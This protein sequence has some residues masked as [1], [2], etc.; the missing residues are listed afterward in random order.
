MST[1]RAILLKGVAD[2]TARGSAVI[3]FPLIAAY[4]GAAGYGAY[5]QVSTI[6]SFVVP[7][8]SLGIA[9]AMVRY[10]AVGGWTR[11]SAR[12]V[13]RIGVVVVTL[14]AVPASA[15]AIFAGPLNDALLGWPLGGALFK[16]GSL[17]IVLG[18]SELWLLELFRA[19]DWLVPYSLLQL[20]Q[21]LALVVAMAVLLPSGHTVVAL[22]Q[23]AVV[24]KGIAVGIALIFAMRLAR[25]GREEPGEPRQPPRLAEMIR[26]GLPFTIAGFGL[27]MVNLSDRLVIGN[28]EGPAD[29]GRYGAA[30]TIASLLLIVSAP[31]MLPVYRRYMTASLTDDSERIAADTRLFHRYVSIALIAVAVYLGIVS[32]PVLEV[33]GGPEFRTGT[34]VTVLLIAGVFLDQWNGLAQYLLICADRTLLLQ[35]LW[36]GCGVMNIALNLILVPLYG[37]EGAAAATLVTF[38]L[39]EA[40]IFF[41]ASRRIPLW[42]LYRFDSCARAGIAAVVA[43]FAALLVLHAL[44]EGTSG[45]V[46]ASA[47]FAATFGAGIALVG[48]LN[49]SDV[50]SLLRAV[51]LR[52]ATSALSS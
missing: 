44:G 35:N 1:S 29:L 3:T 6:V 10:F 25:A 7:F 46:A 5:G 51:G 27:W 26:F 8:A 9:S 49:R 36:L 32:G 13:L 15:M 20:G 43:A 40:A 28:S 42:R 14:S 38:L 11:A 24:L 19:R 17:L 30:Y 47:V 50:A 45:L 22:V 31:L 39:L 37:I 23:A 16:W 34:L 18:A 12:H 21:T 52:R 2:I 33:I 4:A 48:E 41:A